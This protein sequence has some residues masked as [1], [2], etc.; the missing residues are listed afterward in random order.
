MMSEGEEGR[1]RY[2]F[3]G[4]KQAVDLSSYASK[5][6]TKANAQGFKAERPAV[7]EV[8]RTKFT[9]VRGIYEL[10]DLLFA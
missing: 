10:F 6:H 9:P 5:R 4:D 3:F 1:L 7:A 8:P 2:A